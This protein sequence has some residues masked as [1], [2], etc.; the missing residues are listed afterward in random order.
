MSRIK[1]ALLGSSSG[2]VLFACVAI[3]QIE[4]KRRALAEQHK[5]H[6]AVPT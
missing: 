5:R 2:T 6:E 1:R 3:H 4:A